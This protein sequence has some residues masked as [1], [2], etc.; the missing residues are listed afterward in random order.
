MI[1]VLKGNLWT[2]ELAMLPGPGSVNKDLKSK[3]QKMDG[4]K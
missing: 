1:S 3:W 4:L 2:R